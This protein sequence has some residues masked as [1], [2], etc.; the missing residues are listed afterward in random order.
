MSDEIWRMYRSLRYVIQLEGSHS[1]L[2]RHAREYVNYPSSTSIFSTHFDVGVIE[3]GVKWT[4]KMAT[5]QARFVFT[6]HHQRPSW[7][8]LV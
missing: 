4:Y 3:A 7:V 2:D 1:P 8:H 5:F 6:I